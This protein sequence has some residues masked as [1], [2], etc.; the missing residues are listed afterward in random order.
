MQRLIDDYLTREQLAEE[1]DVGLRTII[2]WDAMRI[3]P[4]R[5]KIG[6][7]LYYSRASVR[8]WLA[9]REQ[10]QARASA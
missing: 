5:V 4:P 7:Q 3:G 2:R 8:T 1:L 9:S 10:H 6:K